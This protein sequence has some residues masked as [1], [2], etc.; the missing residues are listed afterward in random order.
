MP[1]SSLRQPGT[2]GPFLAAAAGP[3]DGIYWCIA[4]G[5]YVSPDSDYHLNEVFAWVPNQVSL[6]ANS[7]TPHK[8][9]CV[10]PN[11]HNTTGGTPAVQKWG[12]T[13]CNAPTITA[14]ASH[15]S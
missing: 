1:E 5:S 10:P 2:L 7:A 8:P 13:G 4:V 15:W 11:L 9:T 14:L 6:Q 12:T 3:V